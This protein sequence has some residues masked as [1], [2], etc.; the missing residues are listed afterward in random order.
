VIP[1][2]CYLVTALFLA[3]TMQGFGKLVEMNGAVF[4]Y[5]QN[6]CIQCHGPEEEKGDRSFHQLSAKLSGKQVIDLSKETKVHLLQDILDQL[7]LGEMPPK[8]KDIRQPQTPETQK[9]ISWLTKTLLELEKEKGPQQTVL[10]RLNRREY[11]NSLEDLLGLSSLPFD[12][13]QDFPSDE[14]EHGFTN[15]GD[16]LTLSDQHLDAY[17]QAA[18]RYLRMAFRFEDKIT[19]QNQVIRPE[20]WGYPSRQEKTPWMYRVYQP[21]QYLDFAAGKKQLSDHF[22]LGTFPHTWYRRTKGIQVSGYYKISLTAEAVRRL[23]HPYDPKMIPA[24]LASPMQLALF[25]SRGGAGMGSDSVKSRAKIGHWDLADHKQTKYEVT[26]WMDKRD[27]PFLNWDNGPG[28]SD[29][30]MRDICQKYHTD[31]EFRGKQ[32]SHAWHIIG[33]DLVPGRIVSDVWRGP[34]VRLHD[35]R[36]YGPLPQTF[37]SKAHN[38]F[39]DGERDLSKVDLEL[40]FSRF[41]RR[42]FRRPISKLEIKPYLDIERNARVQLGRNREEAFFLTLKAMLVSPD[43]LYLKEKKSGDERLAPFEIANR[44]S[45]FLWSSLPDNELFLTAKEKKTE[46]RAILKQQ[47]ERLLEDPRSKSFVRGFADSWLRLDKLG[48]MPPASLKFQEFYRYGLK[49]AM[50]EETHRFLAHAIEENIPLTDFIDSEYGFLNQDLARHYG[51][52]GIEGIHFR[53]VSFP[54]DSVRG[55]LLGQASILTLTANGVDTS[56]VIRGIWVLE[57][58]LGTPPS[59]P[60]PDVESIDPD[61]RGAQ[62]VKDLLEKHRSVQA[63]ADCHAKIDPYGFPL[64]YFDPVGGYRPTYYRSRFWKNSTQT[65]ELFPSKPIDG[66]AT[67]T[68]GEKLWGPRSLKKALLSKKKLL[69]QNLALQLLTYGTGRTGSIRDKTQAKEI[70]ESVIANGFGFRDLIIKVATSEAFARK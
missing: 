39:L 15:I 11:R 30:W 2:F 58:L 67:L 1:R 47:V 44:L 23:S 50:L 45:Y 13:T 21:N 27:V 5:L 40:A 64:E 61:V 28:P 14:K 49:E 29:Y 52:Q 31:I 35:F 37:N 3:G 56:P 12:F 41:A 38:V 8:K 18:D 68:T 48:T 70:A 54:D 17:L 16:H 36:I 51:I 55:G 6:Y 10:R 63:C 59:P 53:K 32:G 26:V 66:S 19:P 65:T 69:A 42:A 43:F 4:Q 60:P 24:D 7:N 22:D 46:S 33:K 20:D 9:V 57:S 25:V 34:V 62:T